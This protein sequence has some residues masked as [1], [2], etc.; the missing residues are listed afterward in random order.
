MFSKRILKS[1]HDIKGE[2]SFIFHYNNC[3]L[4]CYGCFNKDLLSDNKNVYTDLEILDIIKENQDFVSNLIFS[5]GEI[6]L[7][8]NIIEFIDEVRKISKCK[9]IIYTNGTNPYVLEKLCD[10]V[11]GIHLDIKTNIFI[12]DKN[13][14]IYGS[15]I[16]ID[17][18]LE[19]MYIVNKHNKGYS[20][21]RTVKYPQ[22]DE[23]YFNLLKDIIS[24]IYPNVEYNQNDFVEI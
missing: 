19:S 10:I 16:I 3:N 7:K 8:P 15:D 23:H 24:K 2:S 21:F 6:T 9:I 13:S 18:I 20:Q 22:Y 5:G 12:C 1:N 4:N 14:E 11:D 17:N